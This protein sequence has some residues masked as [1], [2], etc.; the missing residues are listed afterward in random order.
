MS[1]L[2]YNNRKS[3]KLANKLIENWNT[4]ELEE[5]KFTEWQEFIDN[6]RVEMSFRDVPLVYSELL[7]SSIADVG[8]IISA[9]ISRASGDGG[10]S[11]REI[12]N[13]IA[14]QTDKMARKTDVT[15]KYTLPRECNN[16]GTMFAV[17]GRIR[18]CRT[19]YNPLRY[20][21]GTCL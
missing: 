21:C 1:N 8:K 16:C 7:F 12:R 20:N 14:E 11:S 3:V 2:Q 18:T 9:E 6:W 4:D 5:T 13:A 19:S 10:I 15:S 17:T